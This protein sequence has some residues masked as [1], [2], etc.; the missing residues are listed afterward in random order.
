MPTAITTG[1]VAARA[2]GM[3]AGNP[4]PVYILDQL[5]SS[6]AAAYSVRRLRSG[7]TGKAFNVRRSSDNTTLDIGS[8]SSGDLDVASLLTFCGAGNGFI[9]KWYDQSGN[10]NDV[11]QATTTAQPQVV[12]AGALIQGPTG[13]A[14]LSFNGT[15]Q[16]LVSAANSVGCPLASASRQVT[17]VAEPTTTGSNNTT[18]TYGTNAAIGYAFCQATTTLLL[19]DI[20]GSNIGGPAVSASTWYVLQSA[21]NGSTTGYNIV[22][23]TSGGTLTFTSGAAVNTK[24]SP[25]NIGYYPA[26]SGW[27]FT[28][29]MSEM[30]LLAGANA[31]DG[32]TLMNNE[33]VYFGI[34]V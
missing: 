18:F 8:A 7:Y 13:K 28:G 16:K 2:F 10:G 14:A 19:E 4:A 24:N 34:T 26:A 25:I 23:G 27:W 33:G 29:N 32:T 5:T 3:C 17:S 11:L 1:A 21:I 20:Y 12:N 9:T 31:T 15:S 22:N 30:I 6:A